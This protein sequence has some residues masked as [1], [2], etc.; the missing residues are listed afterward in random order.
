M[1]S[2]FD[3]TSV[4]VPNILGITLVGVLMICNL[5]RLRDKRKESRYILAMM[6]LILSSC[7][8]DPVVY[9]VDGH[10]GFVNWAIIFFGN[11][12]IYI[13]NVLASSCWL[14][15]FAQY[16]NGGLS[17]RHSIV[18]NGLIVF[19]ALV[20]VVNFFEPVA[21]EVDANNVYSR[22]GL[23]FLFLGINYLIMFDV[24][25]VYVSAR[26]RG[27]YLKFLPAWIFMIPTF[28]GAAVQ[29]SFYGVSVIAASLAISLAGALASLQNDYIFLDSLTGLRNRHFLD[30]ILYESSGKKNMLVTGVMLDLNGFK[31]INDKYGHAIGDQALVFAAEILRKSVGS[32]GFVIRYA[33]DEFV[34]IAH[35]HEEDQVQQLLQNIRNGFMDFNRS[36]QVPYRLSVSM[37]Y[38]MQDL[39]SFDSDEFIKVIDSRMYEDKKSFYAQHGDMDRR[40]R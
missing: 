2:S 17:K 30:R 33:G 16:A 23:F 4:Y 37:G 15:F 14:K 35:I 22:K 7:I 34:V 8:M 13:S 5:W 38:S 26:R 29:S 1:N 19:A 25:S 24:I 11:S 31:A 21:F 20:L 3:L 6:F 27:V 39:G 28:V 36:R 9:S 18:I 32:V 12:W 10:P 40:S